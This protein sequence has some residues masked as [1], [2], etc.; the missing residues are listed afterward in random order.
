MDACSSAFRMEPW[1][2]TWWFPCWRSYLT[3]TISI[4]I[5]HLKTV[6]LCTSILTA[7]VSWQSEMNSN[8]AR[9]VGFGWFH[10]SFGSTLLTSRSESIHV[11]VTFS[12]KSRSFCP[13]L[14]SSRAQ[15]PFS[16][17]CAAAQSHVAWRHTPKEEVS[18][19]L[20]PT[21][22]LQISLPA[23]KSEKELNDLSAKPQNQNTKIHKITSLKALLLWFTF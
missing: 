19:C 22:A 2:L 14:S 7:C 16:K 10:V 3:C 21:R 12:C 18:W 8:F 6:A 15:V 23:E 1:A 5:P 13:F 4:W 9:K 11:W 17:H 20:P